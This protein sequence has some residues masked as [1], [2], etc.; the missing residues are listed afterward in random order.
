M[1]IRPK[2]SLRG[3]RPCQ[4]LNRPLPLEPE[5]LLGVLEDCVEFERAEFGV[6]ERRRKPDRKECIDG[7]A[8]SSYFA[9][10][11]QQ[12]RRQRSQSRQVQP[13]HPHPARRRSRG[14]QLQPAR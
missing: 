10:P 5:I 8:K 12:P 2:S 4:A 13:R 7:R 3:C 9:L 1:A 6:F 14:L 11:L